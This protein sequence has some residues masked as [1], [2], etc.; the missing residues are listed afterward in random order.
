MNRNL[1]KKNILQNVYDIDYQQASD[2]KRM[3][4]FNLTT[5]R[6]G[7]TTFFQPNFVEIYNA[8]NK[9]REIILNEDRIEFLIASSPTIENIVINI[10]E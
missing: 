4:L 10:N 2:F 8:L 3:N 7:D 5:Y 6:I 9:K 1:I